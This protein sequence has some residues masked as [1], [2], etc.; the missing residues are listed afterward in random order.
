MQA[1]WNGVRRTVDVEKIFRET[2]QRLMPAVWDPM[3]ANPRF[4]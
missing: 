2:I 1:G 3:T 4:N